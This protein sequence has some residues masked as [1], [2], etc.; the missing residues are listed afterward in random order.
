MARQRGDL[1]LPR[2][3]VRVGP[4]AAQDVRRAEPADVAPVLAVRREDEVPEAVREDISRAEV[5]ARGEH[6][7]VLPHERCGGGRGG[8]DQSFHLAEAQPHEIWHAVRRGERAQGAVRER[9]DLVQV[10]D[11]QQ[12]TWQGLPYYDLCWC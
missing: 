6:V 2:R 8:G 11:D 12:A 5:R 10:A 7:V 9:A 3:V 1:L 4:G